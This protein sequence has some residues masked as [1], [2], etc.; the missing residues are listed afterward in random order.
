MGRGKPGSLPRDVLEFGQEVIPQRR[1]N[2]VREDPDDNRIVEC[3]L[4]AGADVI[5]SGDR[6][7]LKL[8]A[9]EGI[10]ILTPREFLKAH[11]WRRASSRLTRC[12]S[13][14]NS[15]RLK[16][17]SKSLSSSPGK[18]E[19][20]TGQ[21]AGP[22]SRFLGADSCKFSGALYM[23]CLIDCAATGLVSRGERE[24]LWQPEIRLC[25]M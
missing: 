14:T 17:K 23:V 13:K 7:L 21:P 1:V 18:G 5:V 16:M 8:G 22:S 6:H 4:A 19:T 3:A 10:A 25:R 11:L 20:R 2:A 12:G 24:N 9:C 15:R